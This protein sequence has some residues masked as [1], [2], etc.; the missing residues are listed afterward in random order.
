LLQICQSSCLLASPS[1]LELAADIQQYQQFQ[2]Q[3]VTVLPIQTG[4]PSMISPLPF[5][6]ESAVIAHSRPCLVLFTSGTTGP[7]KAVV[8]PRILLDQ[9][10]MLKKNVVTLFCRPPNHMGACRTILSTVFQGGTLDV[11]PRDGAMLWE[12][13]RRWEATILSAPPPIWQLMMDFFQNHIV[14]LPTDEQ[15]K[16][17]CG[18]HSIH[19]P[20]IY[21]AVASPL[22][23]DFWRDLGRPLISVYGCTETGGRVFMSTDKTDPYLKVIRQ[24][25]IRASYQCLSS[26]F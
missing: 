15:D 4:L 16:Y 8:I 23:L 19:F 17:I 24:S 20:G 10:K 13:I 3:S 18:A 7:P 12:R 9:P 6:C 2:G 21:G 5:L 1:L 14:N 11:I 22:L 25:Y 26:K